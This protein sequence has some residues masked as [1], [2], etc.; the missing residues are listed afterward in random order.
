MGMHGVSISD[1]LD[2]VVLPC[3]QILY[4]GREKGMK[5]NFAKFI[6]MNWFTEA[7]SLNSFLSLARNLSKY[8]NIA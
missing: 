7:S 5:K 1:P 2:N 8:M 6:V 4:E 3:T